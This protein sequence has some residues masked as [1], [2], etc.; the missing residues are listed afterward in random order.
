MQ[1]ERNVEALAK[2]SG[3][4][5]ANTSRHLQQL[6]LSG[7]V[8]Q[9]KYGQQVYYSISGDKILAL[10]TAIR[11]VAEENNAAVNQLMQKFLE[12]KDKLEPLEQKQL[13]KKL[14][15]NEIILIDVRPSEEYNSGHIKGAINLPMERLKDEMEKLPVDKE[16]IAYCRGPYCVLSILAV[17]ELRKKGKNVRRLKT[18]FPEWKLANLPV[19]K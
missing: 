17:R 2:V 5:V 18:G 12:D 11:D 9:R 7:I 19:E 13:L 14:K 15:N 8:N 3:L 1:G 4:T 6:K 16:I 10:M